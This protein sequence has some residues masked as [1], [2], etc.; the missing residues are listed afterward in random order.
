MA[1][2]KSPVEW[3]LTPLKKY[4]DFSGRAPRAEYWWFTLGNVIV[5]F[6]VGLLDG[7]LGMG[8]GSGLG[9][10]GPLSIVYTLALLIPGIAVTIRRLHDTN[11]TG[12]WIL[13][14]VIPYAIGIAMMFPA[15]MAAANGEVGAALGAGSIFLI[16]GAVLA[17]VLFVFMVL[18]GT[19]GTNDYGPDPYGEHE[20]LE[21]VFS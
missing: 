13:A 8:G 7:L 18:P 2:E 10:W 21:Q 11:R 20:N 17:L 4:A 19:S 15:M 1:V 12:W 9:A 16:I 5:S 3:A 6:L 14:P